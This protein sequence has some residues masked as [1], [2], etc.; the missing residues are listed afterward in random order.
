MT[1]PARSAGTTDK[2]LTLL[3][4]VL[5]DKGLAATLSMIPWPCSPMFWAVR[6]KR[7]VEADGSPTRVLPEIKNGTMQRQPS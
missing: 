5:L 4:K 2:A 1:P 6:R 7:S 3:S